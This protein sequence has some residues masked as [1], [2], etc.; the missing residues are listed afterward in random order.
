M[1]CEIGDVAAVWGGEVAGMT[2]GLAKMRQEKKV[3]ILADSKAAKAAVRKAGRTGK[4]R[5]RHLREVIN[6]IAEVKEGGGKVKLGW[7]KAAD[8]VA[9]NAAKSGHWTT[10]KSGCPGG[11]WTM[12]RA[13]QEDIP[14]GRC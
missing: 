10:T 2:G 13:E 5:S 6:M 3:L 8:V 4:A 14:G 1:E 11:Y 7:V 9:K 12:G